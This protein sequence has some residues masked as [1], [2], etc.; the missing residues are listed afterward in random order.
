M[1][2]RAVAALAIRP[3]V[4]TYHPPNHRPPH[5]RL[6][7]HRLALLLD[8]TG[9]ELRL[10]RNLR[11]RVQHLPPGAGGQKGPSVAAGS[12]LGVCGID[13]RSPVRLSTISCIRALGLLTLRFRALTA[14]L[15]P[16]SLHPSTLPSSHRQH[17]N[18][19]PSDR[20]PTCH[21]IGSPLLA[22]ACGEC[23]WNTVWWKSV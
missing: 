20:L 23:T 1:P 5:L 9:Q 22:L 3:T 8:A 10:K 12:L 4:P 7:N 16:T 21:S 15:P 2:V 14:G 6:R 11:Q 17:H 18:A 19:R 13:Q